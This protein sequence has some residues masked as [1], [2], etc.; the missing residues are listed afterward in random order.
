LVLGS[1]LGLAFGLLSR[2]VVPALTEHPETFAVVGMAA[3][4]TAIVRAPLTGIVLMV[5]M[6]GD[7]TLVLP[8]L[9]ASLTAYGVADF[10][11]DRPVY[12]ALLERD[13]R[14]GADEKT[15][16]RNLLVEV[17]VAPGAPFEGK[18]VRDLGLPAGCVLV[19]IRRQLRDE[20]PTA[21]SV[22]QAGD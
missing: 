14:R 1:E 4:F 8:L 20:V 7:Y 6:T 21:S 11:C 2:A 17:T 10:L 3:Y 22:L 9:A 18:Q 12:E 19:T 5:E 15:F 13:L 16:A